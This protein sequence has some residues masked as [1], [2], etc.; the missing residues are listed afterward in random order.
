MAAYFSFR[1]LITPYFVRTIYSIGFALLTAGG[2]GWA[3]WAGMRLYAASLP[4]RMAIYYIAIGAGI[5]IVGNLAW[6]MICEFWLL[7]FNVHG[8]LASIEQTVRGGSTASEP[9]KQLAQEEVKSERSRRERSEPKPVS[10]APSRGIL[11]L[12]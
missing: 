4:T 12:S 3:V 2:V 10:V 5:L 7:L 9:A 11:G 6:R 8:L 1:K